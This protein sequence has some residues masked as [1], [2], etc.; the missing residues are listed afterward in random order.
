MNNL[1][2]AHCSHKDF[3][4]ATYYGFVNPEKIEIYITAVTWPPAAHVDIVIFSK[5]AVYPHQLQSSDLCFKWTEPERCS[6]LLPWVGLSGQE[7]VSNVTSC[8]ARH[9]LSWRIS[10]G[11]Q[12]MPLSSPAWH[13]VLINNIS[14]IKLDCWS[15][16]MCSAF[17]YQQYLIT[18]RGNDKNCRTD[19]DGF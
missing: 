10:H 7:L 1:F 14:K 6:L 11:R 17:R 3:H 9:G 13:Y 15:F 5:L 2:V 16:I 8:T 19:V 12:R 4:K 18:F